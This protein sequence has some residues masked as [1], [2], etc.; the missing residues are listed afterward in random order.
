MDK[1]VKAIADALHAIAHAHLDIA[2]AIRESNS[3]ALENMGNA[4]RNIASNEKLAKSQSDLVALFKKG[5]ASIEQG[6]EVWETPQ[7]KA[8]ISPLTSEQVGKRLAAH[9]A[10]NGIL[11]ADYTAYD[12]WKAFWI[13]AGLEEPLEIPNNLT[14]SQQASCWEDVFQ[15]AVREEIVVN[16]AFAGF[17]EFNKKKGL[18]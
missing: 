6:P 17:V 9:F 13:A 14:E 18:S 12:V 2:A 8:P 16:G 7:P 3:I 10:K 4:A 5:F 11:I 1:D 15:F